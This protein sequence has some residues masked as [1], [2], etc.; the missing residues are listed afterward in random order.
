MIVGVCSCKSGC[1]KSKRIE[2]TYVQNKVSRDT[3]VE[4]QPYGLIDQNDI[5]ND[6]IHYELSAG[7]LILSIIFI[8]TVIV[9]IQYGGYYLFEP[10]GKVNSKPNPLKG[11]K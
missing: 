8:E 5:K 2:T 7:N 4:F 3:V 10:V 9:P 6:S 1:A 11:V